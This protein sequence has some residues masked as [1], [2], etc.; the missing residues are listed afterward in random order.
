MVLRIEGTE[1][2]PCSRS[3]ATSAEGPRLEPE[4]ETADH[5]APQ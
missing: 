4:A 2:D 1:I 3:K 5:N